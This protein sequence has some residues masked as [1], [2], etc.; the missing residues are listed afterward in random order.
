M[1]VS[2]R[3]YVGLCCCCRL[4]NGTDLHASVNRQTDIDHEA[5]PVLSQKGLKLK[6]RSAKGSSNLVATGQLYGKGAA[7]TGIATDP[8][9]GYMLLPQVSDPRT[10]RSTIVSELWLGED[11]LAFALPKYIDLGYPH[12][13]IQPHLID[14]AL[15]HVKP[16]FWLEVGSFIGNSAIKT[17]QRIKHKQLDTSVVCVDPFTGDVNMWAWEKDKAKKKE[18][19]FV[20]PE[21][22]EPGI[23]NRFRANVVNAGVAD[24]VVPIVSTSIVA[25][26]LIPRLV[27]ENRLSEL[28]GVI[29][30]DSAHEKGETLL[31]LNMAWKILAPGGILMGDDWP[32]WEAVRL[33]VTEFSRAIE[34]NQESLQTW[35]ARDGF[36]REGNVALHS[37]S[38]QWFVF[39]PAA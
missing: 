8:I 5:A 17:A 32:W 15:D 21:H 9:T 22:G 12:S 36:K 6:R 16:K 27:Q 34:V 20:S 29:Y 3:L 38:G 28:P 37:K 25:M 10:V 19:R 24:V 35:A 18:W 26:K 7:S 23:Y 31:E 39:K 1:K 33:D 4:V 13:N 11:P 14:M 30:L 2:I